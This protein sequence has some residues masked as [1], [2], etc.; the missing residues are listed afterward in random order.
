MKKMLR[1]YLKKNVRC[2]KSYC[3]TAELCLKSSTCDTLATFYMQLKAH[4]KGVIVF[5][6]LT[7]CSFFAVVCDVH[8]I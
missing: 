4:C 6:C 2:K 3:K 1:K 8:L 7:F 5:S